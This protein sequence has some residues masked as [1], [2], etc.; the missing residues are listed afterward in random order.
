MKSYKKH[1]QVWG[2]GKEK[3]YLLLLTSFIVAITVVTI[4]YFAA[5]AENTTL[6]TNPMHITPQPDSYINTNTPTFQWNNNNETQISFMLQINNNYD[7]GTPMYTVTSTS[8][9]PTWTSV[10][11]L[12]DGTWYWR[13]KIQNSTGDWSGWSNI[14]TFHIDTV[15][16]TSTINPLSA[17]MNI[18]S[19]PLIWNGTDDFSGI[20][21][22][23]LYVK[24]N[25]EGEWSILLNNTTSTQTAFTGQNEHT[26]IFKVLTW[27]HAGNQQTTNIDTVT[28]TIDITPPTNPVIKTVTPTNTWVAETQITVSFENMSD[29][30]SGIKTVFYTITQ[31]PVPDTD[32]II[33]S[34][35]TITIYN[36]IS[37]PISTGV[38]YIHT[39]S[40]DNAGNIN[41]TVTTYGPIKIDITSPTT[42]S[43]YSEPEYS[44]GDSNTVYWASSIDMENKVTGYLLEYATTASFTDALSSGW[45]TENSYTH[46]ITDNTYYYRVKAKDQVNNT[47]PWSNITFTIID[48]KKPF[49]A[50][51]I[52]NKNEYTNT[53]VVTIHITPATN[54]TDIN[55]VRISNNQNAYCDW[56]E[57][58]SSFFW[59]ITDQ[60]YGGNRY[61]EM[62]TVYVEVKDFA[63]NKNSMQTNIMLDRVAPTT[64]YIITPPIPTG[65]NGWYNS[66]NITIALTAEDT[67]TYVMETWYQT[68]NTAEWIRYYNP[69]QVNNEGTH[70]F[71]FYSIDAAG[72]HENIQLKTVNVDCTPPA[73]HPILN[74]TE[75]AYYNNTYI[76]NVTIYV[77]VSDNINTT[78]ITPAVTLCI[79]PGDIWLQPPIT[80]TNNGYYPILYKVSDT[81]GNTHVGWLNFT[82]NKQANQPFVNILY[83][84]GDETLTGAIEIQ[85]NATPVTVQ[86]PITINISV[87][88][89]TGEHV[90]AANI[91]NIGKLFFDTTKI[92][93]GEYII[94]ITAVD[95]CN[96]TAHDISNSTFYICNKEIIVELTTNKE[97]FTVNEHIILQIRV[98]NT[99]TTNLSALI[100]TYINGEYIGTDNLYLLPGDN[101]TFTIT[102]KPEHN[103]QYNITAYVYDTQHS[104]LLGKDTI[105]T[106]VT[107]HQTVFSNSGN[108]PGGADFIL[109]ILI[110]VL[111]V[112]STSL[113]YKKIIFQKQ[114]SKKIVS[115]NVVNKHERTINRENSEEKN[116]EDENKWGQ[117]E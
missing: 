113:I 3:P 43:I 2:R 114:E 55:M 109:I 63:D 87:L 24:E 57:Y 50:V 94:K 47:T 48:N 8:Q 59:D 33:S 81:A 11:T 75:S 71:S 72:N 115:V 19:F 30:T 41:T 20:K 100:E 74:G 104:I 42:P 79:K 10:Y 73:A 27:D 90:I 96:R 105:T 82:I 4:T 80:V 60:K 18:T 35:E 106:T 40:M 101:A 110:V 69:I 17:Y 6:S 58:S 84:N 23:T 91:Q 102:Y 5:T 1:Q 97:I 93:N 12:D 83:P 22:Y 103:S 31:D 88:G 65:L 116:K 70:N 108:T 45:I 64:T 28:T 77:N 34:W 39:L 9:N 76:T 66:T 85:W 7:M 49:F 46:L 62:K 111:I 52:N 92:P 98:R 21:N 95:T 53:S 37:I 67:G 54:T 16:P 68:N 89:S 15:P 117:W 13:V 38:Y 14:V 44:T 78:A 25:D 56:M 86:D 26:Y 61:D 32:N 29:N 99:Y 112:I 51:E 36:N 107:K